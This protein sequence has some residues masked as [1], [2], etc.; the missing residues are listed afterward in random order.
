MNSIIPYIYYM[1]HHSD[2][3]L[4]IIVWVLWTQEKRHDKNYTITVK[5]PEVKETNILLTVSTSSS[6]KDQS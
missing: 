6:H 2:S 3:F 4:V 5:E 1:K